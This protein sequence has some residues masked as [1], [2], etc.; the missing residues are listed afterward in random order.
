MARMHF[1]RSE[2]LLRIVRGG[3]DDVDSSSGE[4]DEFLLVYYAS[5]SPA[6]AARADFGGEERGERTSLGCTRSGRRTAAGTNEGSAGGSALSARD[7][8]GR[9]RPR[10]AR[11]KRVPRRERVASLSAR[12]RRRQSQRR[13]G[14]R[15]C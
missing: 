3:P 4:L 11:E 7:H 10:G 9:R 8:R 2:K 14:S 6:A 13:R 12:A 1:V 5:P 15:F